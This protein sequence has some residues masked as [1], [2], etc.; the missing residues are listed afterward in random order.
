MTKAVFFDIDGTLV[1]FDTH[2]I[3]ASTQ[4]A[5]KELHRKGIKIFIA[6][7]R[8]WCLIDNLGDLE[9]DGYIT[10]NGSY[11]FTADQQPIYKSCIPQEDIERLIAFHQ[12]NPIPFVFV[13]DNEMFV[14]S[15]NNRVKAV[16]DLIQIPVPRTAPIEEA[17]GKEI[18]QIMGYFTAEEEKETDIFKSIL[19]HCEPMRWYPL[20]ADI[21]ALGNSKSTGIDKVLEYYGIDL[22][23]TM[24]F[25]D[26]GN[27]IPMLKH[28]ATGVAMGNAEE[29][30]KA[31][32]DYVTSSVDNDGVAKALKHF[33]L[34]G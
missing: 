31:V 4:E 32:A 11:C 10:V 15:V 33:G 22:K 28:V 20:F 1:S 27:D 30:V 29:H 14:T 21:I 8:P 24:A 12:T 34:I 16:S 17:R 25:G 18:L 3:P 9:F 23:D 13:H 6:T 7:G 19:T 26:G 2:R 5:L